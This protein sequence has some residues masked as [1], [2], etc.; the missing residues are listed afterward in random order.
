MKITHA[1]NKHQQGEKILDMVPV[2]FIKKMKALVL[3]KKNL[4]ND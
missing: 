3:K 1:K 2:E 4:L